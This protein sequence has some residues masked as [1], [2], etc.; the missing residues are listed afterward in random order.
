MRM[1]VIKQIELLAAERRDTISL[2]Q[3]IPSF[4]TPEPVKQAAIEAILDGRAAPYS[5]TYGLSELRQAIALDLAEHG[6]SYDWKREIVVTCGAA[7]AIAASLKAFITD[8]RREVILPVPSYASYPEMIHAAD[9]LVRYV[10]LD[11][12]N[13]WKLDLNGIEAMIGPQTAAILIAN[14]NNPTGHCY[15]ESDLRALAEMAA[16]HGAM[17]ICD[18]V[19]KDFV[20][21]GGV[22]YT[23]ATDSRYRDSII[24]IF[25]FSKAYGMTGWRVGFAHGSAAAIDRVVA[26]HDS[27]VTCA[28]VVSQY[29]AIAAIQQGKPYVEEFRK[30]LSGRRDK[31]CRWLDQNAQYFAYIKP[32]SAY[33]VFPRLLGPLNDWQF[34]RLLLADGGVAV[35]PGVAFGPNGAGHVRLCFGRSDE[36]LIAACGRMDKWLESQAVL[37]V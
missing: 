17:L 20:F 24:R 30:T 5:L 25:S 1:S 11:E 6:M 33:F 27:L 14:P 10:T 13:S 34:T 9:G 15:P 28:P 12:H 29:A 8:R 22:A 3:G 18:D 35:V 36:D 2:A 21:D 7:E 32:S 37:A 23:P 16:R 19:Y 31:L 4:D 26:V